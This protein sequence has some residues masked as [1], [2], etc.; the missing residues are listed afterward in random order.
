MKIKDVL[1][2]KKSNKIFRIN[3]DKTL[4]EAMEIF[5]HHRIRSLIVE[6]DKEEV[7][8]IITEKDVLRVCEK[9]HGN[10][11]G[12]KVK[13]AMTPADKMETIN[14]EEPIDKA[15][16]IMTEKRVAHLPVFK[17]KVLVGIVSIGDLIKSLLDKSRKETKRLQDYI[18]GKYP[19][20]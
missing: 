5:A 11:K 18:A 4:C 13:D 16:Q 12:R 9:V 7:V 6:N 19:K 3:K 10:V 20:E 14:R 17:D 8:G 15:M 2:N 1:H